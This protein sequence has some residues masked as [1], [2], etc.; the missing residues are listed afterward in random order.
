MYVC[1][2]R[3]DALPCYRRIGPCAA[4]PK[5]TRNKRKGTYLWRCKKVAF[6][7]AHDAATPEPANEDSFYLRASK[8]CTRGGHA[9]THRGT[10]YDSARATGVS[11]RKDIGGTHDT[12][13]G[14]VSMTSDPTKVRWTAVAATNVKFSPSRLTDTCGVTVS[15]TAS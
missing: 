5:R 11:R 10:L 7:L 3:D 15:P 4:A 8:D 12:Q 13:G 9:Y 6:L 2:Q 1:A 14:I